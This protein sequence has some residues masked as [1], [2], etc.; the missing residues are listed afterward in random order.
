MGF[1]VP[2]QPFYSLLP[3][4]LLYYM[5]GSDDLVEDP[6]YPGTSKSADGHAAEKVFAKAKEE[7]LGIDANWQDSDSSSAEAFSASHPQR[8]AAR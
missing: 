5:R 6:L 7:G 8:A 3:H 4:P 2:G 1:V